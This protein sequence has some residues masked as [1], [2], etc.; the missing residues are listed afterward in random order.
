MNELGKFIESKRKSLG[1]DLNEMADY[2][3]ISRTT[4]WRI[5]SGKNYRISTLKILRTK[6]KISL[7]KIIELQ[8]TGG[9]NNENY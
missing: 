4:L 3:G 8:N 7:K 2:L 9:L 1:L 5:Y 6:L